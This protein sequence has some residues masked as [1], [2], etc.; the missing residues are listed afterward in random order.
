VG[1]TE[2][3]ARACAARP[4]R[5]LAAWG[6]ALAASIAALAFLLTGLTSEGK[7]TNN[8]QSERA[9]ARLVAA[10]PPD[11]ERIVTD[12]IVVRS[13][14]YAV[15]DPQFRAYVTR[16]SRE[17]RASKG[18][19]SLHTWYATRD[20]TQVS[21]DRHA[22]LIP[23]FI[24]DADYAGDVIAGVDRADAD[25]AFVASITG[26]QTRDY[27]F[28]KLS[29]SDLRNG[30]LKVG[31]PAALVVLLLVFGTV[32]AGLVPLLMAIFS[33]IAALGLVAVLSQGFELSIFI[34]NMLTGMGLALGID[35]SLFVIS[36]YR[37]ER[38]AVVSRST[39][40]AHRARQRAAPCCSAGPRS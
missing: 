33:I 36:R 2:R 9:D 24:Y 28:N 34:V 11:P 26:N 40:S 16:L 18:V 27:D 7:G 5:T 37:E 30:E 1:L 4:G 35:Y 31:L 23:L 39:P 19:A 8:P 29:E 22:M 15:D 32:V 12:V 3:I 20:A 17:V 21:P 38:T 6:V 14:R 10:F 25:P 13:N